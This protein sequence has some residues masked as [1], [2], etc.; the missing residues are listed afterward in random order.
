MNRVS[1]TRTACEV[2]ANPRVRAKRAPVSKRVRRAFLDLLATGYSVSAAATVAGVHRQRLY[3]LRDRDAVFREEW[4]QAVE[5]GTDLLEQAAWE[6]ATRGALE[7]SFDEAGRLVSSRR[8][9]DP[10]TVRFLLASRRPAVYSE[11][12]RVDVSGRVDVEHAIAAGPVI[13]LTEVIQ[14]Q[15][16]LEAGDAPLEAGTV[17]R[18]DDE[19]IDTTDGPAP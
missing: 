13:S 14:R 15:L 17:V 19:P 4:Q 8:R 18:V 9:Q 12:T 3:E 10:A 1:V 6:I 5:A 7:E 11:R 16:E 2:P